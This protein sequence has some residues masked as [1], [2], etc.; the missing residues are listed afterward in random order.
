MRGTGVLLVAAGGACGTA[1]RLAWA[2]PGPG[3][4]HSLVAILLVNLAG[5]F[6]LGAL[7]AGGVSRRP[8][9]LLGTGLLG[10]LTTYGT[11]ALDV[12]LLLRD[13]RWADGA[14]YGAGSVVG[15]ALAVWAG[16]ACVRAGRSVRGGRPAG[17]E[18]SV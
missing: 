9:L 10:G 1:L 12:V 15:G 3:H 6:A 17:G 8:R 16:L 5:A 2:H 4:G 13:G 11:L 14:G 7:A 18:E